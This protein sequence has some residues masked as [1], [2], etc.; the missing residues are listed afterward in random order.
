MSTKLET[1]IEKTNCFMAILLR[2]NAGMRRQFRMLP[3]RVVCE[4]RR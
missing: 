3:L 1:V 2:G 4:P